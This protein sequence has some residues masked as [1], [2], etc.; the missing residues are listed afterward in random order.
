MIVPLRLNILVAPPATI[1]P[2]VAIFASLP[3][4]QAQAD[5]STRLARALS[6]SRNFMFKHHLVAEVYLESREQGGPK[7]QFTYDRYPDVERLKLE[8]D[9]V[10]AKKK[11]GR[12]LKSNDWA[13][14]GI[15]AS[16]KEAADLDFD[17]QIAQIA[18]NPSHSYKDKSQG[19]N[20]TKLVSRSIDKMGEHLVFERTR[21]HP[22]NPPYPRYR[23]TSYENIPSGEPLLDHFS[24]PILIGDQRLFLTVR[25][26]ALIELKNARIKAIKG[27]SPPKP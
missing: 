26:T 20:I 3:L 16:T 2:F 9:K 21:E 25:Y 15:P 1:V 10:F 4:L 19:A 17:V 7:E 22:T 12:W 24:G 13:E 5:D 11:G 23:F 14:T 27:R 8:G 6:F 18:W